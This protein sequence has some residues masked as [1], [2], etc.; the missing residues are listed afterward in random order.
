MSPENN[1]PEPKLAP[2]SSGLDRIAE[3]LLGRL[4]MGDIPEG[5]KAGILAELTDELRALRL[6]MS[7][8]SKVMVQQ[9]ELLVSMQN[10]MA[11]WS[12]CLMTWVNAEDGKAFKS[13]MR[14][15]TEE[16]LLPMVEPIEFDEDIASMVEELSQEMEGDGGEPGGDDGGMEEPP[17]IDAEF[18]EVRP[19]KKS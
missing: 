17:V 15:L 4:V 12:N 16:G 13:V 2:A 9:N 11:I 8:Y 18:R 19:G 7:A 10:V 14:R 5:E 6:T 1:S 3:G